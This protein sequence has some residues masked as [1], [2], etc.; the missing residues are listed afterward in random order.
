MESSLLKRVFEMIGW[1]IFLVFLWLVWFW[2]AKRWVFPRK[3]SETEIL[4]EAFNQLSKHDTKTNG[5]NDGNPM[6]A[7]GTGEAPIRM[8]SNESSIPPHVFRRAHGKR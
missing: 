3:R 1:T 6:E 2:A 5:M 7:N 4:A 8:Y